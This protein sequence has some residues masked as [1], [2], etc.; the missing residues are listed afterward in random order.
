M[1][2][3]VFRPYTLSAGRDSFQGSRSYFLL[4]QLRYPVPCCQVRGSRVVGYSEDVRS[5]DLR[6][7]TMFV[8]AGLK[9]TVDVS[10]GIV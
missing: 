4:L 10:G 3:G 8:G 2:K 7:N 9:G 5:V 1:A 6:D